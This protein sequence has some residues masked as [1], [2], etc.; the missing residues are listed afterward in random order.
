MK[1]L[2]LILGI[3]LC[4]L[5]IWTTLPGSDH[6]LSLG[7][8]DTGE[9]ES[10]IIEYTNDERQNH[11]LPA[12]QGDE[13]LSLIAREHSQDMALNNYLSHDNQQGE[14]PTDRARRHGHPVRKN[15]GGGWYTDGIGENIGKMPTGTVDGIG[16]VANSPDAVARAQVQIWMES[17]GHRQN[18]LDPSYTTIGVGV[19]CDDH[20][21]YYSTQDFW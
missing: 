2:A 4:G 8:I 3:M 17:P 19:A 15:L 16:I 21:Y 20:I 13:H 11:G 14:G 7:Q 9:I 10:A 6:F 12:L 5:M 1:T 18:I